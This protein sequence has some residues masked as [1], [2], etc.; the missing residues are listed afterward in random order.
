ME[1]RRAP[2]SP[3]SPRAITCFE[4]PEG[5]YENWQPTM[6]NEG[7]PSGWPPAP[8][9]L[10]GDCSS[11]T[12]GDAVEGRTSVTVKNS[13][14]TLPTSKTEK[15]EKSYGEIEGPGRGPLDLR[16]RGAGGRAVVSATGGPARRTGAGRFF[17]DS[18]GIWPAPPV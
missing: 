9:L 18:G 8:Q 10:R 14:G 6:K 7:Y 17:Y 2:N 13:W 11:A 5:E 3:G 1:E 15:G 4:P 16:V 12:L